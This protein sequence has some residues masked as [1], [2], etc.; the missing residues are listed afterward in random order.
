VVAVGVA[1][2]AGPAGDG[3]CP[4]RAS[5]WPISQVR[6][7]VTQPPGARGVG[8]G[9]ARRSARISP[10]GSRAADRLL[11]AVRDGRGE[12]LDIAVDRGQVGAD[13][14]ARLLPDLLTDSRY[15]AEHCP[16]ARATKGVERPGARL[17][18]ASSALKT[19]GD[20]SLAL[21]AADRAA[22]HGAAIDDPVLTASG[23]YRVANVFLLRARRRTPGASP[24]TLMS[25]SPAH[26]RSGAVSCLPRPPPHSLPLKLGISSARRAPRRG[27]LAGIMW[28]ARDLRSDHRIDLCG[29]PRS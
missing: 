6:A 12:G 25:H 14:L 18:R 23:A 28:T 4:K 22:R 3:R 19:L 7:P 9:A 17:Q 24:W 2:A 13:Q 16:N 8:D 27:R 11:A 26:S 10:G 15:A 1:A 5:T 29:Q 21:V 20:K